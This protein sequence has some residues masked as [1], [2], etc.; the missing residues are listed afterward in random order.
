MRLVKKQVMLP[1]AV[2]GSPTALKSIGWGMRRVRLPPA[3]A[4]SPTALKSIGWGM[5]LIKKARGLETV[6]C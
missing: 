5:R 6:A 1:P 3:E 2:A 4:G